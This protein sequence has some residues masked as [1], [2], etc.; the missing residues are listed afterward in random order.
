[1]QSRPAVTLATDITLGPFTIEPASSRLWREGVE[2]RLRPQAFQAL[3]VLVRHRGRAVSYEQMIAEAWKGT[4]VSRHTVDVTVGE[5]R[6]TLGEYGGWLTHRPKVGYTL[7]VP[8]SDALVRKGWHFWDRRTRQGFE[9]ALEI[10]QQATAECPSDFRAYEGLSVSYLMLATWG[11]RPPREMLPAFLEAHDRA[12][13]LGGLT[14]QLRCN[15]AHALHMFERRFEEAEAE[16]REAIREKPNLASAYVRLSMLYS[17]QGRL[18]EGLDVVRRGYEADPLWP[19]LPVMETAVRF[20]RREYPEA[21]A[22]GATLVELHPYLQVGRVFY[23]QALEFSGRLEE[24]LGQ[25]RLASLMSPDTSWLRALEG[26][27]LAKMRR[28][29]EAAAILDELEQMRAT[30]YVDAYFPAVLCAALNQP[31][32]AFAELERAVEE[33]SSWLWSFPV[34]PKLDYFRGHP[35]FT[36]LSEALRLPAPAFGA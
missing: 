22:R 18:D 36:R 9:R 13:A 7:E 27:C 25:Y 19:L 28:A 24:A 14:P 33:C 26:I 31:A 29:D 23:A 17:T 20:W 8:T 35:R 21:I 12:V 4:F 11:I 1:M 15:R 32:D 10:F 6:K 2:I 34:D 3:L 5:I 30:E 16:L